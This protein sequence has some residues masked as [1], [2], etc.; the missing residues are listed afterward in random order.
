MTHLNTDSKVWGVTIRAWIAIVLVTDVSFIYTL[1]AL[2]NAWVNL[3]GGNVK[4]DVSEPLYTLSIMAVSYYL[5]KDS[6]SSAP[7]ENGNTGV[8]AK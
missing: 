7:A 8:I 2:V 6:K 4:Q 5:G 1:D 3:H